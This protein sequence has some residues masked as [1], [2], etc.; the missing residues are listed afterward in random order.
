MILYLIIMLPFLLLGMW[1]QR[2]VHSSFEQWSQVRS[3]SGRTGAEVAR[4]I[5]DRNGLTNVEIRST[6]GE[7]SDHYDPRNRTVNLS[8][9]V[10]GSASISAVSVAAH[11]VGHAIQHE[12]A[13]APFRARSAVAPAA[14]FSS[15]AFMP[16]FIAGIVL[17]IFTGAGGG[18]GEYCM[19]AAIVL[20][21]VGVLFQLVTLPVEFDASKRAKRQLTDMNISSGGAAEAKGTAQVLNAA[22]M[23]YV[24]AAL[25]AVAQ[26]A[27]FVFQMMAAR[28]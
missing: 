20:F 2:R 24:A 5:L 18:I 25:A 9:S 15:S 6:P 17:Q 21:A 16:L 11:E 23:T 27:Y 28:N 7:L 13:Y 10:F 12:K 14:Q 8:P 19:I 1:A 22:A 4:A 26:L 3:S